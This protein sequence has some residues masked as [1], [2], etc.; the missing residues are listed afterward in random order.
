V[1]QGKVRQG[2]GKARLGQTRWS[3]W[4]L[5]NQIRRKLAL[6]WFYFCHER[7]IWRFFSNDL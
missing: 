5:C 7:S 2:Q 3:A 1:R 4:N 6:H